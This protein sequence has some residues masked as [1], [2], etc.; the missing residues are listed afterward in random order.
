VEGT[1]MKDFT[2]GHHMTTLIGLILETI[3]LSLLQPTPRTYVRTVMLK[4]MKS[5]LYGRQARAGQHKYEQAY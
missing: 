2:L 3:L 1:K 5:N 4:L